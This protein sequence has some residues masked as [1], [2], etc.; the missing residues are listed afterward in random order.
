MKAKAILS[1][2]GALSLVVAFQ[3]CSQPV[4]F[5]EESMTA[6]SLDS[7]ASVEPVVSTPVAEPGTSE[8]GNNLSGKMEVNVRFPVLEKDTRAVKVYHVSIATDHEKVLIKYKN[9]KGV[10]KAVEAVD[11][12]SQLSGWIGSARYITRVG[13]CDL[14]AA[15]IEVKKE[16]DTKKWLI[17]GI[18]KDCKSLELPSKDRMALFSF[19]RKHL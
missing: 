19:I 9:D 11:E 4:N 6:A 5:S 12:K 7:E 10:V 8:L 16:S 17:G 18:E 1:T 3:N 2:V 14:R 13:D 15:D